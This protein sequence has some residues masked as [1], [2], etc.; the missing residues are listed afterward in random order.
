MHEILLE[1]SACKC[2]WDLMMMTSSVV[3]CKVLVAVVA[4]PASNKVALLVWEEEAWV[5]LFHS[6]LLSKMAIRKQLPRKQE[7]MDRATR[8]LRLSKNLQIHGQDKQFRIS[9]LKM[10]QASQE[11]IIMDDKLS[12]EL[13]QP[14]REDEVLKFRKQ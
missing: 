4:S 12:R 5:N 2:K 9:T 1:V 8:L 7:W 6:R 3:E 11:E 13:F 14:K 10:V